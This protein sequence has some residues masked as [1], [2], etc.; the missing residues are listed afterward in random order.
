[1][2]LNSLRIQFTRWQARRRF[3]RR[4]RCTIC[5]NLDYRGH[6]ET[7]LQEQKLE[8]TFEFP[9]LDRDCPLCRLV[10][11]SFE[12]VVDKDCWN[13]RTIYPWNGKEALAGVSL[14]LVK[15]R[16]IRGYIYFQYNKPSHTRQHE[17]GQN[18]GGS[19]E[20][21]EEKLDVGFL[22]YSGDEVTYSTKT[23][24]HLIMSVN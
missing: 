16:P 5:N 8:L 17:D 14:I 22:I 2:S 9:D 3:S 20:D 7:D 19:S 4:P 10:I 21:A 15:D 6:S 23:S 13:A 1:M 18:T 11:L 12:S 24:K